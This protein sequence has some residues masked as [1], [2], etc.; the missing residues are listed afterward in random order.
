MTGWVLEADPGLRR[1]IH[2]GGLLVCAGDMT[3]QTRRGAPLTRAAWSPVSELYDYGNGND[4]GG[5][6][7]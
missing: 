5:R 4:S 3:D 7:F 1:L 2:E 6:G